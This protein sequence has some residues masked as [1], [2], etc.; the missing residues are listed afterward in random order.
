M[1]HKDLEDRKDYHREY[2]RKRREKNRAE[3]QAYKVAKGCADCG[4]NAHHAGLE[5]DHIGDDKAANVGSLMNTSSL[6]WKE[7]AKCEVVCGVC[8][9]IRTWNR[10]VANGKANE[11][12]I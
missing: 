8:H 1:V 12:P 3:V 4:Y 10:M 9:G 6:L 7:I 11:Y 5:F 2:A